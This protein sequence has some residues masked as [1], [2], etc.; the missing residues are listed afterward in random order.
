M[1]QGPLRPLCYSLA[2]LP[3]ATLRS[4]WPIISSQCSSRWGRA[5]ADEKCF[6]IYCV[7]S[8]APWLSTFLFSFLLHWLILDSVLPRPRSSKGMHQ[9]V[10][11]SS[12]G[13]FF[14]WACCFY[15]PVT[16]AI[17][18]SFRSVFSFHFS[19]RNVSIIVRTDNWSAI[20]GDYGY[21]QGDLQQIQWR[22]EGKMVLMLMCPDP[23]LHFNFY[24]ILIYKEMY[25]FNKSAIF[26]LNNKLKVLCKKS[27]QPC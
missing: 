1:L 24:Y 19:S 5:E 22:C 6:K 2:P 3:A 23:K 17:K 8:S 15:W 20:V 18:N 21:C 12:A 26:P 13:A 27:L 10:Y 16:K 25:S 14:D 7:F 4:G 9:V 11:V